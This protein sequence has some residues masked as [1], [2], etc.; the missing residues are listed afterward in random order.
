MGRRRGGRPDSSS[1][2]SS[3]SRAGK[4]RSGVGVGGIVR[5]GALWGRGGGIV[6]CGLQNISCKM[7]GKAFP[8]G[9]IILRIYKHNY[10]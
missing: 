4:S 10:I 1:N 9:G 3:S 5:L 6:Q 7:S 8:Q 2:N